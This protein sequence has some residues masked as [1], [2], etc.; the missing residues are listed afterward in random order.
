MKPSIT[1]KRQKRQRALGDAEYIHIL[2]S[3]PPYL[4]CVL[5]QCVRGRGAVVHWAAFA[6]VQLIQAAVHLA[7]AHEVVRDVINVLHLLALTSLRRAAVRLLQR[8]VLLQV[9]CYFLWRLA[10]CM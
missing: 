5:Q 3:I 2:P 8:F 10:S 1:L 6:S 9:R 7:E 4:A